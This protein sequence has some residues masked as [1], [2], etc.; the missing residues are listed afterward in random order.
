[1]TPDVMWWR[2]MTWLCGAGFALTALFVAAPGLDLWAAGAF[3]T[4]GRGFEAGETALA[5]GLR[6]VYRLAFIAACVAAAAGLTVRLLDPARTRVP[7][8]LWLFPT[9][10]FALGPGLL[11]NGVLKAEWGRARPAQTT[12][13]GGAA[14][15]SPPFEIVSECGDNCSFVSGEGSAAAALA[16]ALIG[17]FWRRLSPTGRRAA[18]GAAA[19]WLAGGAYIRMAPGRHFLS[20]TLL[21]FVMMGLLAAL[22]YRLL[23]V[24][25]AR[26]G[27]GA[28]DYGHDLAH[29]VRSLAAG[30]MRLLR[31]A[32]TPR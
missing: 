26:R 2:V 4:D 9:L 21:A 6:E 23:G 14:Q 18:G 20:D 15:F 25:A 22:L 30:A 32:V 12:E 8:A 16:A 10:L 3:F 7:A 31:R 19:L 13:F 27:H 17:L 29:G 28:A 24:G 5:R 11:V 1:V